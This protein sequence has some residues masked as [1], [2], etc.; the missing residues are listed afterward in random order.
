M[1]TSNEAVITPNSVSAAETNSTLQS[2]AQVGEQ[3]S[4]TVSSEQRQQPI[5]DN[6]RSA[7]GDEECSAGTSGNFPIANAALASCNAILEDYRSSWISKGIALCRIYTTLLEAVPDDESAPAT[8]DCHGLPWGFSRQPVPI[9]IK[10]RTRTKCMGFY[11]YGSRVG[12]NPRVSKPIQIKAWVHIKSDSN[13]EKNYR[14]LL[15][16]NPYP[17][18][19]APAAS[20][21]T[22][23]QTRDIP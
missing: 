20:T 12:Y 22:G 16:P 17:Y 19:Y 11:T 8:R 1:S 6:E 21:R 3:G 9:P 5:H 14:G 18:L 13:V 23:L 10:T 15:N 2:N 4:G 7:T